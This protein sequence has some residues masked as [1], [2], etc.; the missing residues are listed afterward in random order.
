MKRAIL[1]AKKDI[2]ENPEKNKKTKYFV[3]IRVEILFKK[4]KS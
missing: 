4:K 3:K 2:K 1:N